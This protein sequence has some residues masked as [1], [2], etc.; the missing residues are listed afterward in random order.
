[1][2]SYFMT[3]TVNFQWDDDEVRFV[4]YQHDEF[5][6]YINNASSLKQQSADIHVALLGHIILILSQS[7]LFLLYIA[8]LA[9]KQQIPILS[10]LVW[11][12][13][14]SK[15]RSTALEAST[16]TITPRMR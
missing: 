10:S 1:M 13:R 11:P 15:P 14:Y 9:E 7:L 16:L 4:L 2:F 12:D 6:F 5:D 8:W 3:R